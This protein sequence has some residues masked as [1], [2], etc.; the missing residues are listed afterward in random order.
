MKIA[1][2]A[3]WTRDIDAQVT[4]WQRYFD[5]VAGEQY[6][7]RNRPGFVSRFVSLAAGPTLEIMSLPDLLSA[8]QASERVGWAHIALSVGE[9][10]RVD[11]LAQR[12]QQEG[13]LQAAPRWTG[14]GFYEAII[15]DP[16]GNAIEITA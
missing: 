4:F 8:E 9:E 12:A 10:S 13:I 16:D 7:S 6:V 14:D 2:V 5:G 3:L 11:Q 15:R 1:H